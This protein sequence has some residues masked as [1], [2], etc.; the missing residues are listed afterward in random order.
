MERSPRSVDRIVE[1][2]VERWRVERMRAAG[3]PATQ[4]PPPVVAVSRQY[5]A[6]GAAIGHQV[7]EKLGCSYWNRELV[8]EIARTAHVSDR[9]VRAVDERHE[10]GIVETVRGML[11]NGQLSASDYHRELAKV[12]ASIAAHGTAVLIGRGVTFLLPREQVLSVRVV[13]PLEDRVRGL[14]ERRGVTEAEARAEIAEV[15]AER[16]A[17][18][19]DHYNRDAD[20]PSAYD[21]H[22]NTGTMSVE[23]CAA[24]VV[25]AYRTRAP[26]NG[27]G[28]G[29]SSG[30]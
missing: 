26:Q 5:G 20:D 27:N 12:V 15:D 18:V 17:F 14:V 29:A 2:Q 3:R 28:H 25:A 30:T 16:K 8:D 22:V 11:R 21:L 7:A 19:R 4:K 13:C 10:A 9:L 24:V 6:R 1:E 23:Q